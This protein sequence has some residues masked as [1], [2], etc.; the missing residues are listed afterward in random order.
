M[1]FW[2]LS[3]SSVRLVSAIGQNYLGFNPYKMDAK[4]RVSVPP[5][6]RPQAGQKL[7]LLFSRTH[8]MPLVKVL[9]QRAYDMRVETV[10]K[11]E[12]SP[13]KKIAKLGTFAMLC[14]EASVNDQGKLLVPKDLSEKS[15]LAAE[16]ELMVVGRGI[17]F[18][19]WNKDNFE[20][21]LE[22]ELNQDDEDE[23]GIL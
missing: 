1:H 9:S 17:H 8:E 23:L 12:L 10:E 3:R 2:A 20:R 6:W 13:A 15:G 21:A 18:E 14:R 7:F 16:T 11:S 22:I 19:L 5:D 4:F